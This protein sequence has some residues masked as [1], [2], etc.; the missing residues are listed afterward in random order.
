[1]ASEM[2]ENEA[3]REKTDNL[4]VAEYNEPLKDME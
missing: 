4:E 3:K 1:M 2:K